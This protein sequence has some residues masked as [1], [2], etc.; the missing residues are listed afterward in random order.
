M[1]LYQRLLLLI[2]LAAPM[3]AGCNSSSGGD[4]LDS[5]KVGP[6]TFDSSAFDNSTW[7]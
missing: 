6:A 3:L 1:K 2:I 5:N 7:E 4:S